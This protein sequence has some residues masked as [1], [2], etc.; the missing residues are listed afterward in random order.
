MS[1]AQLS[2]PAPASPGTAEAGA[3][4]S[5]RRSPLR[6]FRPSGL[7]WLAWRQSRTAAR[8]LGA[9][10]LLA[11]LVLLVGHFVFRSTLG[12]IDPD[13]AL[14]R[15]GLLAHF[16]DQVEPAIFV[17]PVLIGMFI[18]APL[19]SQEHE[20]G[21]IR[22]VRVQSVSPTRW[23]RTRLAVPALLVL[24]SVGALAAVSTS[25][26]YWDVY[27]LDPPSDPAFQ[28]MTY[29]ALGLAPV[30]WSLYALAVGA[31]IGQF[32]RRTVLA[33]PVTGVVVG[34]SQVLVH[35]VR[36][37]FLPLTDAPSWKTSWSM[38]FV[39]P[40]GSWVVEGG[41][42]LPDGSRVANT[43]CLAGMDCNSRTTLY[44]TW[45]RVHPVSH[46]L[47][48]QL[49]ETALLAAVAGVALYLTFRR[50]ARTAL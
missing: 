21:T 3:D 7:T 26:W 39:Q 48:M 41:Y 18:G 33:V 8:T 42:V 6:P 16:T 44:P 43:V 14:L 46:L 47:P 9:T 28:G 13:S 10:V 49:V 30:A 12:A 31:A 19:L 4:S 36:V 34:L 32:L 35:A 45:A 5:G 29:P 20:Q 23:L 22:L 38:Q 15:I 25:L 2:G 50:V 40:S 27:R 11:V 17:L 1:T 37:H 24:V